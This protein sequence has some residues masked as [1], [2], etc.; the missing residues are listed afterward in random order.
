M[1]KREWRNNVNMTNLTTKMPT[2]N[3]QTGLERESAFVL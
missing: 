3:P 2:L 1:E